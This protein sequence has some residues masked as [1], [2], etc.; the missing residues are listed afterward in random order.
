[1]AVDSGQ[2]KTE[3]KATMTTKRQLRPWAIAAGAIIGLMALT[4]VLANVKP[5][6]DPRAT[7][8]ADLAVGN[9]NTPEAFEARCG[10]PTLRIPGK[11]GSVL[12]YSDSMRAEFEGGSQPHFLHDVVVESK[13]RFTNDW[14]TV[15]PDFAFDQLDCK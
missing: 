8:L 2:S 9:L 13:G 6:P 3:R 4:V 7:F 11:K 14:R 12:Q 15:G 1:M 5:A 10:T